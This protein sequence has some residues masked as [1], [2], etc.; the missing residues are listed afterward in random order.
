MLIWISA[1]T[2]IPT[3]PSRLANA[4]SRELCAPADS[5]L[6]TALGGLQCHSDGGLEMLNSSRARENISWG[7]GG[8]VKMA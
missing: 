2:H 8:K 5:W 1:L 4:T 7:E 3:G 6:A